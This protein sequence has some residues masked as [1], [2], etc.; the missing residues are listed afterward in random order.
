MHLCRYMRMHSYVY[1]TILP[2]NLSGSFRYL[3]SITRVGK[4]SHLGSDGFPQM[5]SNPLGCGVVNATGTNESTDFIIERNVFDC[6]PGKM[7]AGGGVNVECAHCI[8]QATKRVKHGGVEAI[9]TN[10]SFTVD[11]GSM[12]SAQPSS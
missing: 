9:T 8:V 1:D 4:I 6:P 3:K 10:E 2:S 11:S 7:L 5:L 12:A